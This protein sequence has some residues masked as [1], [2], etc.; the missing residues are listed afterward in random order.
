[1]TSAEVWEATRT[2]SFIPKSSRGRLSSLVSSSSTKLKSWRFWE[3]KV[4]RPGGQPRTG[5]AGTCPPSKQRVGKTQGRDNNQIQ[6]TR[7]PRASDPDQWQLPGLKSCWPLIRKATA[8]ICRPGQRSVATVTAPRASIV[9][10]IDPEG[11]RQDRRPGQRSSPNRQQLPG[12]ESCW[13]S[14]RKATARIS[15]TRSTIRS[16]PATAPRA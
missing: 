6:A 1:M 9:L 4:H 3:N 11:N 12:L 13:H 2:S 15:P 7:C 14:I 16:R 8:R 5:S 10:A